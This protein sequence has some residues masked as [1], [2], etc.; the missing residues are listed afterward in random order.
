MKRTIL[1]FA[2][3]AL[4]SFSL[5]ANAQSDPSATGRR[6][7]LSVG[8]MASVGQP[9]YAGRG[10]AESS[11]Y[12]LFGYGAFVDYRASRWLQLEA[13]ARWLNYNKYEDINENNYLIGLREPI[14]TFGKLTPYGKVLIGTGSGKFLNGSATNIAYGGGADYRLTKRLSVRGD[15][16]YQRWRVNPTLHPY[17]GSIGVS[18]KIF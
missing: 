11:P 10:I 13:E 4:M 16:E 17:V 9:D 7:S 15:F 14:H 12:K 1:F 8:G 5:T 18:Y 3:I 6:N 2:L